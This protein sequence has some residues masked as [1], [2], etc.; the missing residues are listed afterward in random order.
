MRR[1]SNNYRHYDEKVVNH[2]RLDEILGL[3]A[4]FTLSEIT[5]LIEDIAH[6]KRR[7]DEVLD[8]KLKELQARRRSINAICGLLRAKI[9]RLKKADSVTSA[10][11]PR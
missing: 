11:L 9:R 3:Y 6:G 5:R 2:L 7:L 10:V 8:D 1:S 4:G